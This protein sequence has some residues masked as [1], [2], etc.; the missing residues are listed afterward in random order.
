MARK[1][2]CALITRRNLT[3]V[4]IGLYL[5][6]RIGMVT[7]SRVVTQMNPPDWIDAVYPLGACILLV[8]LVSINLRSL[9]SFHI[10][11]LT[12][13]LMIVGMLLS[14][15]LTQ[16][17]TPFP[18]P[19][20]INLSLLYVP[21]AGGLMA[22]VIIGRSKIK[23]PTAPNLRYLLF[24]IIS[25]MI[26]GAFI[27]LLIRVRSTSLSFQHATFGQLA[28]L[29]VQQLTYAALSEEPFFRGFLWGALR[30]AGLGDHSACVIQGS[31]FWFAHLY[32][33]GNF[34]LSLWLIVPIGAV[35]FSGLVWF[36]RSV[37]TSMIAHGLMNGL[38]QAIGYFNL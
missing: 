32:Y 3:W 38:G 16:L 22:I 31:L 14:A 21:I 2:P 19:S 13:V 9:Q 5:A 7:L 29:P 10:D 15:L 28:L 23:A 8:F 25:G 36:S 1:P 35:I 4:A 12:L 11:W 27:G 26:A 30:E 18:V 37:S 24:A 34:P 6:L 33:L 20:P 17:K